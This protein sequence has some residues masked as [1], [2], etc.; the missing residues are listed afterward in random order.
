MILA[1]FFVAG[2]P[3]SQ[4]SKRIVQPQGA[5]HPRMIEQSKKLGPWRTAVAAEAMV[6]RQRLP[7]VIMRPVYLLAS[8]RC[9]TPKKPTRPYPSLDLDKMVRA[10]GDALVHG[11]LLGDDRQIIDLMATKRWCREG[12]DAGCTITLYDTEV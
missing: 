2:D 7:A 5:R 11:Q 10:V 6:A 9:R 4:G 3:A 8:F 1:K 12:E